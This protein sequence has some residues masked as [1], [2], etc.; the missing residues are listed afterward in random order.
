M[1]ANETTIHHSANEESLKIPKVYTNSLVKK[2]K[3]RCHSKKQ[4]QPK[5]SIL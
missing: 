4:K 2:T 3:R 5:E 1:I